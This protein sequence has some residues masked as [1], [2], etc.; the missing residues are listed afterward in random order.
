[1]RFAVKVTK[2]ILKYNGEPYHIDELNQ[3]L[4][5]NTHE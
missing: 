3:I 4:E 2:R 1:M 5:E